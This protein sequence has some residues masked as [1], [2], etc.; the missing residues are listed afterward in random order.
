LFHDFL[1]VGR[2]I[3]ADQDLCTITPRTRVGDALA[4]MRKYDYD[5]LPVLAGGV[6]VGVFSYRSLARGLGHIRRQDDPMA[7]QVEDLVEDL[8]FVRPSEE[9]GS[10]VA[11]LHRD[12]AVLVG[13]EE[14]LL[15]VATA[16]D[17]TDFLWTATQPFVLLQ[18]IELAV[19][20]LMRSVCDDD[21][22]AGCIAEA[23]PSESVRT[24][25]ALQEF[26]LGEIIGVILNPRNF[27]T[28]FS[29]CFGRNR[30][31]VASTLEP[32][33]GIRNKVFHFRGDVTPEELEVLADIGRW[34]RRKVMVHT[35]TAA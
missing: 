6:V 11:P 32:V 34:L 14:R 18:D 22:M 10:I 25:V 17:I 9:V 8:E 1:R 15:A 19:R 7:A 2:V 35:G 28:V 20:A 24:T 13:D 5:Q 30:E 16:A 21:E 3:P 29:G 31:L 27:G 23:F 12:G 26:T 33:R 4:V